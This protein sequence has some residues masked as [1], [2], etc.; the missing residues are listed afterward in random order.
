MYIQSENRKI[1]KFNLI[2]K[3]KFGDECKFRHVNFNDINQVFVDLWFIKAENVS[4]K[5]EIQQINKTIINFKKSKCDVTTSEVYALEKRQYSSFFKEKPELP[6]EHSKSRSR[7]EETVESEDS[8]IDDETYCNDQ[9]TNKHDRSTQSK[10]KTINSNMDLEKRLDKLQMEL[11]NLHRENKT[12]K[13][14]MEKKIEEVENRQN[15]I[16]KV[17][18]DF[19]NEFK[20]SFKDLT[21]FEQM[22][23]LLGKMEERM[24]ANWNK[25]MRDS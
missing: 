10:C 19:K 24:Q 9:I 1:C 17:M 12:F 20:E 23:D 4:L 18:V 14:E 25:R 16:E 11:Q 15:L 2:K 22:Q 13:K 7:K 6:A 21:T 5:K 8:G 3:C